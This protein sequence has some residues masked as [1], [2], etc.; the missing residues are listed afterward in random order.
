MTDDIKTID[1]VAGD[2]V[3]QDLLFVVDNAPF[4]LSIYTDFKSQWRISEDATEKVDLTVQKTDLVG[5]ILTL[6]FSGENTRKMLG[7]GV[8]DIEA[9][10]GPHTIFKVFTSV[11][12]D[13]T[14]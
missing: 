2:Y 5:G 8:V 13:V 12:Q 9:V 14:R 6:V 11:T 1:I 4:D 3:A 10:P 7:D